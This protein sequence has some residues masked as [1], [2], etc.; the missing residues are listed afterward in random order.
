MRR[1]AL[2]VMIAWPAL[3]AAPARAAQ[4]FDEPTR[5]FARSLDL[6]AWQRLAV[7]HGGRLKVL[8][9][10]ARNRVKAFFGRRDID[11]TGAVFSFLEVYFNAPA[12]LDRPVIKVHGAALRRRLAASA[13]A[14][15]GDAIRRTG[16]AA[17]IDL[18]GPDTPLLRV[19]SVQAIRGRP[20]KIDDARLGSLAA[21]PGQLAGDLSL[22]PSVQ[23]VQAGLDA[24]VSGDALRVVPP[25]GPGRIYAAPEELPILADTGWEQFQPD[26][27]LALHR[28]F[29]DLGAAWRER[30][31]DR[32]NALLTELAGTLQARGGSAYPPAWRREVE[33]VHNR[34]RGF[35]VAWIGFAAASVVLLAGLV[36]ARARARTAGLVIL[37]GSTIFLAFG[38]AVRWV[39]S[40]RGWRLPP[41]TNEY[42]S[43]LAAALLGALA[44]LVLER[45]F[46]Q[47]IFALAAA[48]VA[49]ASL[50]G[51]FFEPGGM[52]GDINAA[53]GILVSPILTW[54]V[55]TLVMG[56]AMIGMSLVASVAYLLA[57][58]RQTRDAAFA[59]PAPSASADLTS[60]P[61][62]ALAQLDRCNLVL[63]QLAA[64]MLTIGV[65]LGAVWADRAWGRW[66]GWDPK[67]TWALMTCIIYVGVIHLRFTCSDRRRGLWTAVC[68]IAG[69]AVMAFTWY[70]VNR[71]LAGLHSYA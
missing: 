8:D 19:P 55:A 7:Q 20:P 1:L 45:L 12:Y 48:L 38:V 46:R 67:E 61:A 16:R 54:H 13:P 56:Y 41:L 37:A 44:A 63:I 26:D 18:M 64:C 70:G 31:A 10:F 65:A 9:S 49:T 58:W 51:A 43:V 23:R 62:G 39:L 6:R 52:H 17:P 27:A 24:F 4:V 69:S 25:A 29:A 57:A 59:R 53:T 68:S 22:R 15:A 42:E 40:G 11:G 28:R 50:L 35:T 2:A 5:T 32:A 33:C 3:A 66:W 36:F 34:L 30:H 71:L 47:G 21:L 14:P 60:P